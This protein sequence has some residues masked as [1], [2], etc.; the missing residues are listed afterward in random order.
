MISYSLFLKKK[1]NGIEIGCLFTKLSLNKDDPNS[2][3]ERL[4]FHLL[5]LTESSLNI[6]N[7]FSHLFFLS[8]N[9]FRECLITSMT[10]KV[11]SS[12]LMVEENQMKI[13]FYLSFI[14]RF[15]TSTSIYYFSKETNDKNY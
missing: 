15:I 3:I 11:V 6:A 10:K 7:I 8:K 14:F 2:I 12:Y 4:N 1:Q 5:R 9:K 13:L